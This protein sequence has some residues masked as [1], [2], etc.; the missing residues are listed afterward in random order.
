MRLAEILA[1]RDPG[2]AKDSKPE[3]KYVERM[4]LGIVIEYPK[5]AQR[6]YHNKDGKVVYQKTMRYPYGFFEGTKGRDGDEVD[7]ILGPSQRF[8]DVFVVHMLDKGP[9]VEQREDEDKVLIGFSTADAAKMGFL[10]MYP[11]EFFGGMT[12]LPV[13]TFK[14]RLATASLPYRAKTIHA[15]GTISGART[16]QVCGKKIRRAVGRG[17]AGE[18]TCTLKAGLSPTPMGAGGAPASLSYGVQHAAADKCPKC[19]GKKFSLMP[20]DFETAKCASCG[21]TWDTQ[22]GVKACGCKDHKKPTTVDE[23]ETDE[24]EQ[25]AC[26]CKK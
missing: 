22:A 11:R 16:C 9:D 2:S 17:M 6:K 14:Q 3:A 13:E 19:G 23:I 4:G 7:A 24:T 20:T 21:K 12:I 8:D 10:Q 18:H 5:G 26:G 15:V 25:T 1:A